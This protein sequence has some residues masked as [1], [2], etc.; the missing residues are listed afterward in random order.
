MHARFG[1]KKGITGE[2]RLQAGERAAD[3]SFVGAQHR[4]CAL[5]RRRPASSMPVEAGRQLSLSREGPGLA[6]AP[7]CR[8][9]RKQLTRTP[10]VLDL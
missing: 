10:D 2:W 5:L 3:A 9:K 6:Q 7:E 1:R 4:R 8:A